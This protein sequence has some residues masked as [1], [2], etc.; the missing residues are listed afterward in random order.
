[1]ALVLGLAVFPCADMAAQQGIAGRWRIDVYDITPTP[2]YGELMF[3]DS[4]GAWRGRA[5]FSN[6]NGAP[7]ALTHLLVDEAGRVEFVVAGEGGASFTG[8]MAGGPQQLRGAVTADGG[9][10]GRWAAARLDPAIEFY[11]V[12]PR[13]RLRQLVGGVSVEHLFLPAPLVA[14]AAREAS[15]ADLAGTYDRLARA[16]GLAPLAGTALQQDGPDR[17]LGFVQ[18]PAVLAAVQR[19][20]EQLRAAL[21]ADTT[22]GQFDALFR[23]D[24]RWRLDVHDAA[25]DFARMRRRGLQWSDVT[26]AL[27]ATGSIGDSGLGAGAVPLALE[28][29]RMLGA[30]DSAAVTRLL[31]TARS[32]APESARALGILLA[33]YP[34]ADDW[35]RQALAF[36]VRARWIA[37]DGASRSPAEV[38]AATWLAIMPGDSARARARPAFVS[39]LFGLPQAVPRY[40]VS[41]ATMAHLVTPLNWT[42]G[43][44]LDRHGAAELTTVLH[45]LES[46]VRS[47]LFVA[48][49]DERLRIVSVK[50]RS[51]ESTSGFLERQEAIAVEPSYIPL[52][53]LGAVLHEWGHLL[54]EGWRFDQAVLAAPDSGEVILPGL[55]PWLVEGIA[56][57]W[58]DLVLGPVL[59]RW[60]LI[61][62]AEAEKRVR[63]AGSELDPHVTGYLMARAAVGAAVAKGTAAPVAIRHL[64]EA[65]GPAAVVADPLFAS[66]LQDSGDIVPLIVHAPSRRFMVPETTFTVD[67]RV[68]D[69]VST[70]IR[71]PVP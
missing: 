67:T 39:Q 24:G 54:A 34:E 47:D 38:V 51:E 43:Q 68:P 37:Q 50:Q 46:P 27:V 48:R 8:A 41:T 9:R 35:H 25:L 63:L 57:V 11:A 69:L 29:L 55:N 21:P 66:G 71:T 28:R 16:S 59:S 62:F 2:W 58:T 19:T 61:G 52:L 14:A 3:T 44:W 31:A 5:V 23:P 56:E 26:P 6:W 15:L 13:F 60:P 7:V 18:R 20:L 40:G 36:L 70:T 30:S 1:M 45:L 10:R 49:Q 32:T 22:R 65:G 53:A 17:M 33:A 12:L 64:I 42:A 4:A